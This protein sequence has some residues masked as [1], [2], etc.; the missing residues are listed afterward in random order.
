MKWHDD[1]VWSAPRYRITVRGDLYVAEYEV[2]SWFDQVAMRARQ[3]HELGAH[4]DLD[5]LK[6]ACAR[7]ARRV[8]KG[9]AA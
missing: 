5:K 2:A 8:R 1:H 9:E 7:H 6:A 3:L 4:R